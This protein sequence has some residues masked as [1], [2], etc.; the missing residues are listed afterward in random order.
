MKWAHTHNQRHVWSLNQKWNLKDQ[1]NSSFSTSHKP[2]SP[3]RPLFPNGLLLTFANL[4][5]PTTTKLCCK[6][7]QVRG[8]PREWEGRPG[9]VSWA[10]RDIAVVVVDFEGEMAN[11]LPFAALD[12]VVVV[13]L[14]RFSGSSHRDKLYM[15]NMAA[16]VHTCLCEF[17]GEA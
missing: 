4:W 13:F 17:A 7:R 12:V 8:A 2:L 15:W 16:L 11:G 3:L 5:A 10:S 9:H 6:F 14:P 1:N